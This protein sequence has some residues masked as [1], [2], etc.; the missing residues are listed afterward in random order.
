[1][2]LALGDAA[3]T[4]RELVVQTRAATEAQARGR[5]ADERA[6]MAREVHDVVG[7]TLAGVTIQ[8]AAAEAAFDVDRASA[9]AALARARASATQAMAALRSTVAGLRAEPDTAPLPGLAD[10]D[11]LL[12]PPRRAGVRVHVDDRLPPGDVVPPTPSLVAYRVIQESLTNVV[13]HADARNVWTVLEVKDDQLH[14]T[15]EDDGQGRIDGPFPSHPA[16]FG[17]RGMAERVHAAGGL[18]TLGERPGGGFAVSAV[19]P[20]TG[21]VRAASRSRASG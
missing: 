20:L 12:D 4:R 11:D 10:L 8:L 6:Q 13:R 18:L 14:I 16:G 17:L 21:R 7:H 19:L 3:R 5:I 2:P 15:V 9:R 1:M